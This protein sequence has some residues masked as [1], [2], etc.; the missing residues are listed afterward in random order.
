MT[1]RPHSGIAWAAPFAVVLAGCIFP[2]P[3]EE[4]PGSD[5]AQNSIPVIVSIDADHQ[6]PGPLVIDPSIKPAPISLTVRD[7]D[8]EDRIHIYFYVDYNNPDPTPPVSEC[9]GPASDTD[10]N[11]SCEIDKLCQTNGVLVE[12]MVIDRSATLTGEPLFRAVPE[13]TGISFRSW[14]LRCL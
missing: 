6:P 9:H 2:P 14:L 5:G 8:P 13:G 7:L 4:N 12:A 3:L 11:L 1:P 10:R